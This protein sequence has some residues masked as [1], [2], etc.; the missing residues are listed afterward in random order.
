MQQILDRN[1]NARILACAPN[2][3]AADLIAQKLMSRGTSQ[4]FRL[5]SVSR[6]F[7]DLP[8]CLRDFSLSNDNQV[9]VV[10]RLEQLISYRVVVAT[11][12]SAGIPAN[13]G[14]KRGYYSHIFIDEAGQG[15][16]PEVIVP[17]KGIAD[18]N[19][20]IIIAGD[21]QQLGPVIHSPLAKSLGLQTSY[22]ARM[23]S[24][25]IYDLNTNR[26]IT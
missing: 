6:R 13:L 18:E 11:C 16:E 20:N 5:N 4:V 3:A 15:K 23:M 26:G 9:F 17:I 14:A 24:R 19:T 2:N 21:N 25:S 12:L 1:P 10:P 22:L 7:D 8:H